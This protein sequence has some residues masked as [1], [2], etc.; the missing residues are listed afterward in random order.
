MF[1]VRSGSAPLRVPPCEHAPRAERVPATR[2]SRAFEREVR[3]PAVDVLQEPPAVLPALAAN[4]IDRLREA[5]V[6]R[7]AGG[8]ELVKRAQDVIV[9]ARREGEL[10]RRRLD[11]GAG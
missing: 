7:R 3:L 9:P 6:A 10:K 4:E 2:F 1:A 5:L 11:A 8:R